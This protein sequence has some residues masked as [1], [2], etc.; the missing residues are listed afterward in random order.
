L[1][2]SKNFI[3]LCGLVLEKGFF[4]LCVFCDQTPAKQ[5]K[6]TFLL[7]FHI[8]NIVKKI[9]KQVKRKVLLKKLFFGSFKKFF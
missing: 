4:Y 1:L 8:K 6:R 3:D 9:K 2:V 5:K 7:F